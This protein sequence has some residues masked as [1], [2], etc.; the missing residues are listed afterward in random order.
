MAKSGK[1]FNDL[2]K[3]LRGEELT[4]LVVQNTERLGA[5]KRKQKRGE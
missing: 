2:S 3:G 4:K 5:I 1:E